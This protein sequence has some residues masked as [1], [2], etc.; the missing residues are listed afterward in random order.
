MDELRRSGRG[1]VSGQSGSVGGVSNL[2]RGDWRVKL[3]GIQVLVEVGSKVRL[4]FSDRVLLCWLG[5]YCFYPSE[6]LTV[7]F[8]GPGFGCVFTSVLLLNNFLYK[9]GFGR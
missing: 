3:E 5:L 1:F 7:R 4:P 6:R 8:V 2:R 9:C